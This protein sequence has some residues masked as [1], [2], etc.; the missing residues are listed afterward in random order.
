MPL[1]LTNIAKDE[2]VSDTELIKAYASILSAL[3]ERSIIRT[4]NVVGELGERYATI[5]FNENPSLPSLELVPTNSK[6]IDAI[7]DSGNSYSIKSLSGR[8][9]RTGCF[10]LEADHPQNEKAFDYLL[11]VILTDSM[12]LLAMYEFSWD[13]FWLHKSWSKPQK[14]WFLSLSKKNLNIGNQLYISK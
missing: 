1:D 8:I 7:S 11:V 2:S 10:H 6:D 12:E 9:V 4:K 3:R 5:A 14:S 13:Q